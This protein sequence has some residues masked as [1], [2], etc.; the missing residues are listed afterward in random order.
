MLF[1]IPEIRGRIIN[2]TSDKTIR[3]NYT[4]KSSIFLALSKSC[5]FSFCFQTLV[6]VENPITTMERKR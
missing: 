1:M 6:M 3:N 2:P 5:S 4:T